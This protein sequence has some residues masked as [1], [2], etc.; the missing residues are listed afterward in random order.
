MPWFWEAHDFLLRTELSSFIGKSLYLWLDAISAPRYGKSD[1][2]MGVANRRRI[3]EVCEE[4]IAPLYFGYLPDLPDEEDGLDLEN[5]ESTQ[6]PWTAYPPPRDEPDMLKVRWVDSWRQVQKERATF[7]IFVTWLGE[8]VGMSLTFNGQRRVFGRS[9]N[10][11]SPGETI[12]T[13]EMT[14][15]GYDQVIGMVLHINTHH[16]WDRRDPHA[17]LQ[18]VTVRSHSIPESC[19]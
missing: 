7:E 11:A 1:K 4:Q 8:A 5:A 2:F 3:A 12:D 15:Q 18:A 9:D 19:I 10:D 14:L 17:Y 6:I 16:I 13:E